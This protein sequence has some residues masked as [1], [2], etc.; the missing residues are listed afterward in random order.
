V[1]ITSNKEKGNLPAPFLRRCVYFYIGFP[2]DKS[3]RMKW[4]KTVVDAHY[5]THES[6][7]SEDL[8]DAACERFWAV[9]DAG[10]PHKKP[11]TSE[12]LD[13]LEVLRGFPEATQAKS[14]PRVAGIVERLKQLDSKLPYPELLFKIQEDWRHAARA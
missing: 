4:L 3:E 10:D 5:K 1:I 2:D 8:V 6:P 9:R 14:S 13:W 11:S 7:P 12:F